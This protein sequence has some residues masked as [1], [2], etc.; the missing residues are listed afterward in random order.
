MKLN[1]NY[2][3][4]GVILIISLFFFSTVFSTD[5]VFGDEGYYSSTAMWI[6]QNHVLPKYVPMFQTE[7]YHEQF[8]SKP[9]FI[10][11]ESFFYLIGGEAGMKFLIPLFSILTAFMIYIFL[12]RYEKPKAGIVGA[13]LFMLVPSL[14]THGVL[15]YVD[16]LLLLVSTCAIYFG[17]KSFEENNKQYAIV[18]GIFAGLS[19]L[20]KVSGIFVMIFFILYFLYFKKYNKW[21]LFV[22]IIIIAIIMVAPWYLIRNPIITGNICYGP[23]NNGCGPVSDISIPT[24]NDLEYVGRTAAGG[25]EAN[26]LDFGL[27]NY[28]NFAYGFAFTVIFLFSIAFIGV[29]KKIIDKELILWLISIIPLLYFSTWRAEDTARYLLP[30]VV[31]MAIISG[32]FI[33]NAHEKIK[34]YN[35]MIAIFFIIILIASASYYGYEKITIMKQVKQFSPG[36]FDACDWVKE[37]TPQDSIILTKFASRVAYQC[38]RKIGY[39]PHGPTVFL[40][41]NDSSYE[42]MKLHGIDYVYIIEGLISNQELAEYY[43]YRFVQYIESSPHFKLVYDNRNVYG[44][45]GVRIYEVLYD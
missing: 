18:A 37:N 7:I 9:L 14:I 5:I 27:L 16:T 43:P 24:N 12:K 35:S 32:I 15:S 45:N 17:M 28:F 25:T 44:V 40:A 3:A 29:R 6:A 21:K 23:L 38:D 19:V 11:S 1:L 33:S 4:A 41:Y 2:I 13:L 8:I 30:L 26:L 34:K 31:P 36:F 10:L 42:H 22:T 39:I 20:S